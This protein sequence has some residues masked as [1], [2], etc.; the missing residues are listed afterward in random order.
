MLADQMLCL[1]EIIYVYSKYN[2][3]KTTITILAAAI[4]TS[5]A[6]LTTTYYIKYYYIVYSY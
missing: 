2:K 4:Y 5:T 3:Y 1:L 6:I